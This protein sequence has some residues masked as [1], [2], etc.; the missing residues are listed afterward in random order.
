MLIFF[1]FH[2]STVLL[3]VP[4]HARF[5]RMLD[6]NISNRTM[7]VNVLTDLPCAVNLFLSAAAKLR[8]TSSFARAALNMTTSWMVCRGKER[9]FS[10]IGYA[11]DTGI[12]CASRSCTGSLNLG[13]S[14][15]GAVTPYPYALL[16]CDTS[17]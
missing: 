4:S 16:I 14:A 12:G 10:S 17:S 2:F 3:L 15:S 6:A 5:I 7:Y 8:D 1:S 11:V 13:N 9:C